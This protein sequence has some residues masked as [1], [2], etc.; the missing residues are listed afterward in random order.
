M[1]KQTKLQKV[2]KKVKKFYKSYKI[3]IEDSI[4]V[5]SVLLVLG[6]ISLLTLRSMN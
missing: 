4:L 3:L 1:K 6:F 2:S 5:F